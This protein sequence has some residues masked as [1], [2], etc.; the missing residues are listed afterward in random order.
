MQWGPKWP[1]AAAALQ[2]S[3]AATDDRHRTTTPPAATHPQTP[4]P[5]LPPPPSI[6]HRLVSIHV[7]PVLRPS[8]GTAP[9]GATAIVPA[10]GPCPASLCGAGSVPNTAPREHSRRTAAILTLR[11]VQHEYPPRPRHSPP[12]ACA[13]ARHCAAPQNTSSSLHVKAL[14]GPSA[15]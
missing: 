6:T 13:S 3:I 9:T 10:S 1:L 4:P 12:P 11:S 8:D 2:A 14:Q 15:P 5:P 7:L